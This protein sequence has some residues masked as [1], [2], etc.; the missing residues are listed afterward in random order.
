MEP[1]MHGPETVIYQQTR[2]SMSTTTDL[3]GCKVDVEYLNPTKDHSTSS[4][5]MAT[6]RSSSTLCARTS[7]TST[8]LGA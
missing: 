7:A 5:W 3:N 4:A 2:V 6:I 8:H 1:S